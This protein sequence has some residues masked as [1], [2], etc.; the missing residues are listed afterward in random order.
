MNSPHVLE[1][2][3]VH[4]CSMFRLCYLWWHSV[5]A[6]CVHV[7][8]S[9]LIESCPI[10]EFPPVFPFV[11]SYPNSNEC[12]H[13]GNVCCKVHVSLF[14]LEWESNFIM[15][16]RGALQQSCLQCRLPRAFR[17]WKDLH[18][19]ESLDELQLTCSRCISNKSWPLKLHFY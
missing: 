9:V 4:I 8:T 12:V 17:S 13:H 5:S 19:F 16:I 1:F 3:A 7:C 11:L 18:V 14:G 10:L 2:R 6:V 15:N